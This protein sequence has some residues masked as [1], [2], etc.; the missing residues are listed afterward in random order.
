MKEFADVAKAVEDVRKENP[1]V[2]SWTNFV[3]IEFV[4]NAQLAVGG[5]A[6]MCFLPDEAKP[7]AFVSKAIYINVGTLQPVA[8]ESL[9]E[10]AKAAVELDKPWVLDPVAA[11]LGDTRNSVIQKLKQYPPDIIRGNASEIITL[12][13]LWGLESSK[14]GKVEGVDSTDTVQEAFQSALALAQYTGGAVAVSGEVDLVLNSNKA[15]HITGGSE[16]LKSIT[17]A[18]CSLGGIMTVFAAVTDSL[19]AALVSSLAYKQA[20]DK[21]QKE[22]QGTASFR[23]SFIDNLSLI[24]ANTIVEY[25]KDHMQEV[26]I[27]E[28]SA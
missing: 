28:K 1:L 21:A 4:A 6:A 14:K 13:N 17:G 15:Y 3:T 12:A 7:L 20:S 27:N 11:G 23:T 26:N 9:P 25:A 24:N 19:T 8:V 10:A 22:Q 16:M 5:R 18:G 2:G